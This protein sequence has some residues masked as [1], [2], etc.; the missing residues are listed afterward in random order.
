MW[1]E[2][3]AGIQGGAGTS[4]GGSERAAGLAAKQVPTRGLHPVSTFSHCAVSP[5]SALYLLWQFPMIALRFTS[6]PVVADTYNLHHVIQLQLV[7]KG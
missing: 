6:E 4:H 2:C 3:R 1:H 7:C 5:S